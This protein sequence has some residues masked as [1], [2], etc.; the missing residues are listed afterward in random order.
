MADAAA[1]KAAEATHVGST[2]TFPTMSPTEFP[3][4]KC[5]E[6]GVAMASFKRQVA[7]KLDAYAQRNRRSDGVIARSVFAYPGRHESAT[8]QAL[9]GLA[10]ARG[11][12]ALCAG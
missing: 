12:V 6:S 2:P 7:P 9:G 10:Q 11:L 8:W 4:E 5:Y 1:S 3:R